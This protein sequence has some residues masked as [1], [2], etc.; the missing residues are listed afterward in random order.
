MSARIGMVDDH[1][2]VVFG[3]T[4]IINS[5]PGLRLVRSARTARDLVEAEVR[6]D[7]VLLDLQLA[8]DSTPADNVKVLRRLGVPIIAYTGGDRPELVRAAARAGVSGM[9]RKSETPTVI[10]STV[11]SV[12]QGKPIATPDWAAA[13]NEDRDFVSAQLT[14]REAEVLG[15]YASGETADR[16]GS[17]LHISRE[18]VLDHIRR[19]RGKYASVDRPAPTKVDLFRRAVEDGLVEQHD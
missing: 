14:D 3:T 5:H 7:L 19:I 9:I 1:P 10:V 6:F 8:D 2:A 13:L 15:L 17:A 12:L 4:A 11:L 18:T 16:V